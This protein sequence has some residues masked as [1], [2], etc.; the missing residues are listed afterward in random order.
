M[1]QFP[2]SWTFL[3]L[4]SVFTFQKRDL[5]AVH[6]LNNLFQREEFTKAD[7][8]AVCAQLD[9]DSWLNQHKSWI[10][11]FGNYD[12]NVLAV[13]LQSRGYEITWFDARK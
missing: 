4:S 11:G 6:A 1:E 2:E 13:A 10:P 7:L 5:C 8:D 12:F 3:L 9:P